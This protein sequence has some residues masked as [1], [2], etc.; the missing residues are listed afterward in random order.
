MTLPSG[1]RVTTEI[2]WRGALIFAAIDVV[3]VG[4]L[5]RRI[6]RERFLELRGALVIAAG[7]YWFLLWAAMSYFYWCVIL[8]VASLLARRRTSPRE[9]IEQRV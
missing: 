1:P 3:L 8:A 6:K 9:A 5:A 7:V 4:I 2:L